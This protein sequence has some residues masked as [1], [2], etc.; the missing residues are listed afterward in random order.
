MKLAWANAPN[1]PPKGI[2]S[3]F[4]PIIGQATDPTSR[5]IAGT[6]PRNQTATL[7]L[8][9]EWV[10]SK[11]GEYF[12]TPSITGLRDDFAVTD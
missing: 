6:D 3:G 7:S 11:G 9:E 1:F 5:T 12:F 2:E 8:P 10:I 4:D